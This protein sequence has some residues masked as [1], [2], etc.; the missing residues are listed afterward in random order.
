MWTF[1]SEQKIS[2]IG[3]V[4]VGG[5][6]GQNPTVLIGSIFYAKHSIIIDEEKGDFDV[7]KAE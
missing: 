1:G 3:K 5:L 2:Q 4:S 6:P 7:G